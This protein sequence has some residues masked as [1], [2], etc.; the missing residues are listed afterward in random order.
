MP[1]H[2]AGL[3]V[4]GGGCVLR[5]PTAANPS[6]VAQGVPWVRASGEGEATCAALN[7]SS[8]VAAAV[9]ALP[10][11]FV[12]GEPGLS[13]H[14]STPFLPQPCLSKTADVR[15]GPGLQHSGR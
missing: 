5:R 4:L 2:A 1:A 15:L 9:P 11:I 6:P 10:A 8:R 7:V 3:C 12:M 14:L 13:G